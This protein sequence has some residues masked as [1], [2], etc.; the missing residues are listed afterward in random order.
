MNDRS[1]Q[2]AAWALFSSGQEPDDHERQCLERA[3]QDD[4]SAAEFASDQRLHRLLT[5]VGPIDS[6][7]DE[8]VADVM[9]NVAADSRSEQNMP[10]PVLQQTA[11]PEHSAVRR[12]VPHNRRNRTSLLSLPVLMLCCST[13]ATAAA[14]LVLLNRYQDLR[15][16]VTDAQ[17]KLQSQKI[18]FEARLTAERNRKAASEP[19]LPVAEGPKI[20]VPKAP[21]SVHEPLPP[22]VRKRTHSWGAPWAGA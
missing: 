8:F 5:A 1:E 13:M 15:T 4:T 7:Q 14:L 11:T 6:S 9:K 16:Q 20:D 18:E 22:V 21:E 17:Q 2:T 3:L 19:P 10:Q 12:R